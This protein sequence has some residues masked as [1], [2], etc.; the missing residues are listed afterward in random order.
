MTEKWDERLHL[1]K[2]T[3]DDG[4]VFWWLVPGDGTR[5][6]LLGTI[7]QVA[8]VWQALGQLLAAGEHDGEI[9]GD[10]W[11]ITVTMTTAEASE[12]YGIPSR[13]LRSACASGQIKAQKVGK[14]WL[15]SASSFHS[16]RLKWPQT[17]TWAQSSE[18]HE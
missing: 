12:L 8:E 5:A 1:Q 13:T 6:F 9:P 15:M 3:E 10:H 2:T 4:L 14:T 17:R 18:N 16:W 7:Q 11:Q